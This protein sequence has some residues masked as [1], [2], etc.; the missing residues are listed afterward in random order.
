[1]SRVR[2]K[3]KSLSSSSAAG[4]G[5]SRGMGGPG[6]GFDFLY[7][8]TLYKRATPGLATGP[9]VAAPDPLQEPKSSK[10]NVCFFDLFDMA[11]QGLGEVPGGQKTHRLLIP[12]PER[13]KIR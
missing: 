13:H 9:R 8:V 10:K 3:L 1:M 7:I 12:K 6:G 2:T 11:S 5:G 4:A